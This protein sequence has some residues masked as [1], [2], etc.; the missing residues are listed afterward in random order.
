MQRSRRTP[1]PQNRYA[2]DLTT[3]PATASANPASGWVQR[4]EPAPA[5]P[6]T[7]SPPSTSVSH[8]IRSFPWTCLPATVLV[9]G[10]NRGFGRAL[11]AELLGRG[12]AVYAG[13][14][15][16]GQVDLPDAKDR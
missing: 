3:S 11:A 6:G 4:R 12:A 9:T 13:A 1:G 2:G 15:D 7:P 14:R 8:F 5:A 16:P 10:A